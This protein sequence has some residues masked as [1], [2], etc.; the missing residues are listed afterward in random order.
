MGLRRTQNRCTTYADQ[1]NPR[2]KPMDHDPAI[3]A[4]GLTKS[5]GSSTVL[6]GI[7]LQV[8]RG[9]VFALLGPNGAGKTTMVRILSTL[10]RPDAGRASGCRVRRAARARRGAPAD[11]PDR[12][13]RRDRRA[14]DRRGEPAHD[15]SALRVEPAATPGAGPPICSRS[16]TCPMP[17]DARSSKYSGGMRRRLDLAA[18]L[19]G[20]PSVIF[21]DEPT[22]GSGPAEP[23]GDVADPRRVRD[24]R[25]HRLPD[26]PVPGGGRSARRPHRGDERR[27]RSWRRA[28]RRRSRRRS[29]TS[30]WRS[31]WPTPRRWTPPSTGSAPG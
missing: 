10:L 22:T 28:P 30:D 6:D 25:G 8:P 9:S 7:D 23:A 20:R 31:R 21:L 15:G 24:H 12:A 29:P 2:R 18:G 14:A 1:P 17:G 4:T 19:V 13:E 16:S 5:F 11:Q 3:L 27:R 26:H